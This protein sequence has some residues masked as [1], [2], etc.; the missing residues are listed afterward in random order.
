MTTKQL[1]KTSAR[2]TRSARGAEARPVRTA[3]HV[4]PEIHAASRALEGPVVALF[5]EQRAAHG[6][7]P[8]R[9]DTRLRR[10]AE[11]HSAEMLQHGYFAHDDAHG[12]WDARIRRYVT[13]G[14]VGEILSFGS[15]VYATPAGMVE[16]WMQSADHRAVILRRALRRV[17]LGVATG[18]FKGEHAVS[19]ATADFCS[20]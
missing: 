2:A 19:L 5:N 3:P 6:L 12:S 18:T 13:R 20:D 15:G 7:P 17:G 16:A 14:E 8:L 9:V 1:P 4:S 10:A 11:A